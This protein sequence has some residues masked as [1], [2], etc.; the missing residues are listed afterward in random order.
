M[1]TCYLRKRYNQRFSERIVMC[2]RYY[3]DDETAREIEKMVLDLDKSMKFQGKRDIN[4]SQ[5]AVVLCRNDQKL[6]AEWMEWGFPG[7]DKGK[8]LVN[9]RAEGITEKRTFR[10]SV[11]HHRCVIPARGFYEWNAR[12]EKFHFENLRENKNLYLA[13]CFRLF[14]E[15]QRFVII[16]TA[17]NESM[18]PVHQRMPLIMEQN[19]IEDW[20]MDDEATEH[21]LKKIPEQLQRYTHYEQMSLF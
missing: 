10:D 11:L 16:T 19:E 6:T 7:Y 17:A 4:P 18:L 2:G 8:L 1:E 13:G 9:A 15:Q 5:K 20:I 12:K 14:Q 3:V 21:M